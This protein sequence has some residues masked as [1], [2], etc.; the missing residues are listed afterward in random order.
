[1][2]SMMVTYPYFVG[3]CSYLGI[4]YIA[5]STNLAAFLSTPINNTL[6]TSPYYP[7]PETN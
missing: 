2:F 3:W 7:K 6:S 1:M 5:Q 4:N